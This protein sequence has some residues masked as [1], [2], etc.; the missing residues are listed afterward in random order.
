M[1]KKIIFV[2]FISF[3]Y[4]FSVA[5]TVKTP[6]EIY[7]ELFID[8]Q[9][10]Q[11]FPDGKTFV[12]CIPKRDPEA[13]LT[14][15]LSIKN[16]PAIKFS[17][18]DF[19]LANF[20]LPV[21]PTSNYQSDVNQNVKEHIKQ[22]WTVLGRNPDK[23]VTG[24]SL[25]SLPNPYIV[26]G[27][28]FREIYYWDSYFTM[29]GLKESNEVTIMENMVKNFAYLINQY[30]HIPNGNRSYYVSRSQPPFFSLMV[31]LLAAVKGDKVYEEFLPALEKEYKYWTKA[32]EANLLSAGAD[33]GVVKITQYLVNRYWDNRVTPRQESYREDVETA[34]K[35]TSDK[36]LTYKNL[37]S[38]AASGWDF[39]SRWF[40]DG[41]NI[42][43]IQTTSI[44]P[45]DLNSLLYHLEMII[46]KTYLAKADLQKA[47]EYAT[48]AKNRKAFIAKY[49][50]NKTDGFYYDYNFKT[51]LQEKIPTLAA[52]YPLFFNL[53]KSKQAKKVAE[54]VKA[55]FLQI[56]GVTTTLNRTGQQ[57]DAP[58]GWAPL[59]WITIQGL[60]NY[61]HTELA[62]EIANR[63]I[64]VNVDVFKRTGKL[65]EKY[66]VMDT[67]LEA[68]GGE[69]PSQDGFGWTNGVLLKLMNNY[70]K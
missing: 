9:M 32:D 7:K 8:V 29:L 10:Q 64:K 56:G 12:D 61:K 17:L 24:S 52:L 67:N 26:P 39:S 21:N 11:I 50:W 4:N 28:R 13:I 66:N 69:Y 46:S 19:V 49:C 1:L 5:Q 65:M 15:Y 70:Q 45:V 20:E 51:G 18:K 47:N 48:K 63:W 36:E 31:G 16:N 43:T 60:E 3:V 33:N 44:I 14:D 58:N 57:W 30:G 59:Q 25:L 23:I 62:K 42:N 38:G 2:V 34:Q 35:S 22:L 6:D 40:A 55:D 54:K 27:G 41:K 37:R 53:S 68:G